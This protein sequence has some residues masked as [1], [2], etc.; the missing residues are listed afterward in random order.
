M[1][2]STIGTIIK[3]KM[4]K[5]NTDINN[6][7]ELL[8][9]INEATYKKVSNGLFTNKTYPPMLEESYKDI[10]T[11]LIRSQKYESTPYN[12]LPYFSFGSINLN[13]SFKELVYFKS[14]IDIYIK[15]IS[16]LYKLGR[17]VPNYQVY[18]LEDVRWKFIR[19]IPSLVEPLSLN[20]EQ[21]NFSLSAHNILKILVEIKKYNTE[22]D[23]NIIAKNLSDYLFGN[24]NRTTNFGIDKIKLDKDIR[25]GSGIS[26]SSTKK[27]IYVIEDYDFI[28]IINIII[29]NT[30]KD[31]NKFKKDIDILTNKKDGKAGKVTLSNMT[32]GFFI[33]D[34][35][36]KND[37][38]SQFFI[39]QK[40]KLKI[41]LNIIIQ[42]YNKIN[43]KTIIENNITKL[44]DKE[45]SDFSEELVSIKTTIVL[46]SETKESYRIE[47]L[48]R[49]RNKKIK[50]DK[51][52]KNYNI[53]SIKIKKIKSKIK[54]ITDPELFNKY[55]N[56]IDT[57][58]YMVYDIYYEKK[59]Y[60]E[61]YD[62]LD[63]QLSGFGSF[64]LKFS[65]KVKYSVPKIPSVPSSIKMKV[66]KIKDIKIK[67]IKINNQ[68][69]QNQYQVN[70]NK[71]RVEENKSLSGINK[72]IIFI[73]KHGGLMNE[74]GLLN[75]TQLYKS[76]NIKKSILSQF[77]RT[78]IDKY[79]YDSGYIILQWSKKSLKDTNKWKVLKFDDIFD[80]LTRNTYRS[81]KEVIRDKI[82]NLL[83]N[84][85]FYIQ[86]TENWIGT[87][88][89]KKTIEKYCKETSTSYRKCKI[90]K[91]I[92]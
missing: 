13:S 56:I 81:K 82:K 50:I 44:I 45:V 27:P 28:D 73:R 70:Q 24:K 65:L 61:F 25:L 90:V 15:S 69:I 23:Q 55:K 3:N 51:M 78:E 11:K 35:K 38:E 62:E 19:R 22:V 75:L 87:H 14:D 42:L 72:Y 6:L 37:T 43:R 92:K 30:Q 79:L 63:R 8:K 84:R 83:T 64:K 59:L 91:A 60:N 29:S 9:E 47:L 49:L 1:Y 21:E 74:Y 48:N 58:N 40:E 39:R 5:Y 41:V 53:A 68:I 52:I 80:D 46:N 54:N 67:D 85:S 10:Q 26:S 4:L 76:G 12:F 71:M 2:N 77:G 88:S 32:N 57:V 16:K 20:S 34:I 66:K 18:E 36:E 86:H 89:I 31:H 7:K 33:K 17:L